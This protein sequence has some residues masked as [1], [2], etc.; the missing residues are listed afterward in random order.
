MGRDIARQGSVSSS[1]MPESA[2]NPTETDEVR[3]VS[4]CKKALDQAAR[5]CRGHRCRD[6]HGRAA[7]GAG[8]GAGLWRSLRLLRGFVLLSPLLLSKA[9]CLSRLRLGLALGAAAL[10]PLG[11]LGAGQL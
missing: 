2:G 3:D 6:R 11:P 5:A 7:I 4:C 10:E 9:G 1:A 8:P